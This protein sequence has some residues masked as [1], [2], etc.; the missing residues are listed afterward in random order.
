MEKLIEVVKSPSA[1]D[2]TSN[3]VGEI[4]DESWYCL[5]THARDSDA[6]EDS[7]FR[8]ALERL[9]GESE[10]VKIHRYNHWACGWWESLAVRANTTEF[11]IAEKIERELSDYP[12]LCEMDFSNLQ[13]EYGEVCEHC[14]E[15]CCSCD[16]EDV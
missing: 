4:P 16:C 2:S 6:L 14:G 3:Y 12:V 11:E 1:L 15:D 13:L 5:L 7:N 8:V 9:G 10:N